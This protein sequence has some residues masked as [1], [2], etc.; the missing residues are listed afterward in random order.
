MAHTAKVLTI[1]V[2]AYNI[3]PYIEQCLDSFLDEELLPLLDIVV[4]NDGSTDETAAKVKKYIDR[5]PESF[6]LVTQENGGYG[7]AVNHAIALAEGIYFKTVDGDDWV[8]TKELLTVVCY[9]RD[10]T[11]RSDVVVTDYRWVR[12][13]DGREI[14]QI[15]TDFAQKQYRHTYSFDE[16][17][18]KVYLNMHAVTIRTALLKSHHIKL[19]EHCFYVDAQYVLRPVPYI[20]TVVFLPEMVYQY[21]LG[22]DG[23]SMN[24]ESMQ[25]N[26]L[27]HEKVLQSIIRLYEQE[28]NSS[29]AKKA[30]LAKGAAKL[31]TSQVKIYL[32]FQS[33]RRWKR[34]IQQLVD[35]IAE[36]YPEIFHACSNRAVKLLHSTNYIIYPAASFLL[37]L[38]H[39]LHYR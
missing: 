39:A 36:N 11:E 30:Y 16:I 37:R 18:D 10:N 22:T 12:H 32:S 21:R 23:Q 33:S 6:R 3:A 19:D 28:D 34:K 24:L 25:K 17:A 38:Q 9:L 2:A 27:Q 13:Q 5:F 1:A 26:Y 7:A 8:N 35:T 29:L 31:M 4:I 20:E 14:R 15:R